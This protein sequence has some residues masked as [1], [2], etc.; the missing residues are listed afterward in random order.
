MNK[1][2][3]QQLTKTLSKETLGRLNVVYE[4]LDQHIEESE[5]K[6]NLKKMIEL[7]AVLSQEE[8]KIQILDMVQKTTFAGKK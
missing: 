2:I 5:S 8:G 6:Q 4:I 7:I 1:K 3:D